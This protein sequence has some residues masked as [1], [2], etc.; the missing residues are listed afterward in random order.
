MLKHINAKFEIYCKKKKR[1]NLITS[2]ISQH[3]VFKKTTDF[4]SL[5][6]IE[7]KAAQTTERKRGRITSDAVLE[8]RVSICL[9]AVSFGSFPWCDHLFDYVIN[10]I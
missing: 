10:D 2:I 8:C 5:T 1:V 6:K 7:K 3:E 9:C 4:G